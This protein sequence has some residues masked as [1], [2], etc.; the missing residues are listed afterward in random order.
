MPWTVSLSS[1]FII[2]I[3]RKPTHCEAGESLWLEVIAMTKV[4]HNEAENISHLRTEK[5][6][7]WKLWELSDW[8]ICHHNYWELKE[9]KAFN[10]PVSHWLMPVTRRVKSMRVGTLFSPQSLGHSVVIS[11][12]NQNKV[13]THS[14]KATSAVWHPLKL[15][16]TVRIHLPVRKQKPGKIRWLVQGHTAS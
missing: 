9:N 16:S 12:I 2:N 14:E 6:L 3:S 13:Q 15:I 11:S 4:K 5:A 8:I 7:I 10:Q 1:L